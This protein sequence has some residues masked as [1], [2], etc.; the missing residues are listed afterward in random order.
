VESKL[1]TK[2]GGNADFC[3]ALFIGN[4]YE[5]LCI[6]IFCVKVVTISNED[7]TLYGCITGNPIGV[8]QLTGLFDKA[9][10]FAHYNNH[11]F[12]AWAPLNKFFIASIVNFAI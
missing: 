2:F 6:R 12:I 8:I 5:F 4:D 1:W 11:V 9:I 10:S 7:F 3:L